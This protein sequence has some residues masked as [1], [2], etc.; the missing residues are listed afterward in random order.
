MSKLQRPYMRRTPAKPP[1]I[2]KATFLTQY[3]SSS[4]VMLLASF[5]FTFLSH[6]AQVYPWVKYRRI[7]DQELLRRKQVKIKQRLQLSQITVS[8]SHRRNPYLI[9]G[10]MYFR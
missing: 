2:L 3:Q 10:F 8:D 1:E 5:W 4:C 9:C 6:I 7:V